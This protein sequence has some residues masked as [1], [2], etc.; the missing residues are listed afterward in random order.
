MV[1]VAG[2]LDLVDEQFGRGGAQVDA[3]LAHRGQR[4][5]GRRCELDVVVADDR[6]FLGDGQAIAQRVLE[7]AERDQVVR[8]HHG[9]RPAPPGDGEDRPARLAATVDGHPHLVHHGQVAIRAIRLGHGLPH[10]G[11]PVGHLVH[12]EA[13]AGEGDSLVIKTE[14]VRRGQPRAGHVVDGHRA[15]P[16]AARVVDEDDGDAVPAQLVD[17]TQVAAHRGEQDAIRTLLLEQRQVVPLPISGAVAAGQDQRQASLRRDALDPARDIGEEGVA[18]VQ[19]E[20]RDGTAAPGPQLT[21]GLVADET[22]LLDRGA[23]PQ[24]RGRRNPVGPVQRVRNGAERDSG[25][26]SDVADAD[27]HLP[28]PIENET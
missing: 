7:E 19:H 6:Q 14:Q 5:G 1:V 27:A 28:P 9:G 3:R 12:R 8:A 11:Q 26:V 18:H 20:Q 24:Q 17:A 13:A 22:E 4:H 25:P 21:R 2:P 16:A 10:A 23:D 15:L